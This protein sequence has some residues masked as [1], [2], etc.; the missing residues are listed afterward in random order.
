MVRNIGGEGHQRYGNKS[1]KIAVYI[2][3]TQET[4]RERGM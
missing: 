1:R 3:H 2:V 4:E